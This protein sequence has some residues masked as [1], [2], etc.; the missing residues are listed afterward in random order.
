[1][2]EQ[3]FGW[4]S[5]RE[6]KTALLCEGGGQ[7]TMYGVGALQCFFDRRVTFPYY[8]GVSAAAANLASHLA[9]HRDRCE[10]FYTEYVNRKE[11]MGLACLLKTG[12]FIDLNYIFDVITNHEDC[13]DYD[14]LCA[15]EDE[16]C[17]VVTNALTG[18]AE[19]LG[20]RSF[21]ERK[22]TALMASSALPVVCKP[23]EIA[24]MPYFDGGVADSIPVERALADGCER[25]VAILSR[26]AGFQKQPE[27]GHW[28][29]ERILRKYPEIVKA[30]SMRHERYIASL[31]L[32]EQLEEEGRAMI[33][34]PRES[35]SI[36][37]LTRRPI[38][39]LRQV[40]RI[41]YQDAEAALLR[42]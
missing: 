29:Y 4:E 26:P 11:Y 3:F 35:M 12:S 25:V 5:L 23:V 10:R 33:I 1:M 27:K 17:I 34:R 31:K 21:D 16:I 37:T 2:A 36:N 15:V 41:G 38:G 9:G 24:G 39:L 6:P 20:N 30:L 19:Y 18:Q 14:T 7:R 40:G 13:I 32:L 22:C 28:L 8:I 42:G